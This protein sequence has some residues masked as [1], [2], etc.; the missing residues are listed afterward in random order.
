[1]IFEPL[2]C[3]CTTISCTNNADGKRY[4]VRACSGSWGTST[5][6]C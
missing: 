3:N 4:K 6:D 2:D 5:C 1:M